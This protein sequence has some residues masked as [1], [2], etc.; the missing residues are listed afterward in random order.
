MERAEDAVSVLKAAIDEDIMSL[1]AQDDP[2]RRNPY[3]SY[4]IS[5]I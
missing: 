3:V 1:G 5:A 2:Y 4:S